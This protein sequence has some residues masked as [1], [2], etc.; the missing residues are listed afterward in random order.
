MKK[1]TILFIVLDLLMIIFYFFTYGPISYFRDLLITTAMSTK[2]HKYLA[3]TLYSE[4]MIA[5]VMDNNT[6]ES[7]LENTDTSDIKFEEIIEKDNYESVYEEQVLKH[8]QNDIYKIVKLSGEGYNGYMIVLYDASRITLGVPSSLGITGKTLTNIAI[9][10]GALVAINAGGFADIDG[11][12]NGGTPTGT[13]IKNGKIIYTGVPTGWPGGLIGFNND[14]VLVLTTDNANDAIK[15]GMKDAVEFG[16]FLVV[17]GKKAI[18]KGNGGSGISPR[19]AIAQRKDG[20]VLLFII[21]GRQPGYSIGISLA[22]LTDLVYKY[23]AYN[24]ANLDGGAS[25]TLVVDKKLYNKPAGI[26]GDGQRRLPNA[27]IIK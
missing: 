19:T 26:G 13:V 20:I 14:N 17:N 9:E 23:G 10:N 16:P 1:R 12:S 2:E 25:T 3:R 27:W 21:D 4:K 22:E 15:N 24:A 5:K 8:N 7:F 11:A 6:I 18:T